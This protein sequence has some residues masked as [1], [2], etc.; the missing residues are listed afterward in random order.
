MSDGEYKT[1]TCSYRFDGGEWGFTIKA[2]SFEEAQRRVKAMVW[3]SV[4]GELHAIIPTA[5][6]AGLLV[7]ACC[8]IMN[9]IATWR[10]ATPPPERG[11]WQ[12]QG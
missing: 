4:D 6:G 5:P 3:A 7:R 1:Y 11:R 8:W 9:S 12:E 10:R 2:R